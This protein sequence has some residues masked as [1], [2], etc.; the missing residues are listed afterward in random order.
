MDTYTV[1]VVDDDPTTRLLLKSILATKFTVELFETGEAC[2][3]RIRNDLPDLFLLDV[4]LPGVN[5]YDVC[6]QIKQVPAGEHVPVIFISGHDDHAAIL[7]GYDAGAQDYVTKPF[8]VAGLFRKIE[9]LQRIEQERQALLGQVQASDEL[10][11]LVLANLDEYAILI[12]FLRT[13]SECGCAKDVADAIQHVFDAYHLMGAVQVRMRNAENTYSKA[14]ENWPMELA[15]IHHVR[16]M[17]RIFE[18]KSRAAFNFDHMTVLV[19]NM[20]IADA[21]MCGRIRDN[22]AIAAESADAK[23]KALQSFADNTAIQHDIHE[24]LQG[25]E[26]TVQDYSKRCDQARYE[27]SVYTTQSLEEMS[28]AIAPLGMTTQQEDE[29]LDMIKRRANGLIDIYDITGT[30]RQTLDSIIR[31]LETILQQAR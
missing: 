25:L 14:G 23:L 13:L 10:A 24:L 30:T 15:V 16:T 2:L 17:G 28:A 27:S 6:R 26:H 7:A 3:E 9:N 8:D 18:F 22:V 4:G 31:K 1:Y 11:S 12:K 21:E 19:T 5:G 29:F 20:P